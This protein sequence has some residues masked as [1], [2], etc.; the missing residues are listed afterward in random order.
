MTLGARN[1]TPAEG[2]SV[3]LSFPLGLVVVGGG[4]VGKFLG[5]LQW[6]S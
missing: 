2:A 4:V 6:S 5:I 3:E 1:S